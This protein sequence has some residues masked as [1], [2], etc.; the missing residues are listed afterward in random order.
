MSMYL[1]NP[2]LHPTG[3]EPGEFIEAHGAGRPGDEDGR[4]VSRDL[5][6]PTD[7]SEPQ[8]ETSP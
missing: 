8:E 1:P 2:D 6:R 5:H 7:A 4:A 3:C